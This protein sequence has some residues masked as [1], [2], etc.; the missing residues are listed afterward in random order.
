MVCPVCH[1]QN[2]EGDDSCA[3]CGADLTGNDVPEQATT[4]HGKLLGAHL[5]ELGAPAPEI[6]DGD[7]TAREAI[8]RMRRDSADCLLITEGGRLV[9][10]FTDR[11]ALLKVRAGHE[12]DRPVRELMTHD[13]VV[14]R[15]DDPI[16]VAI[17]KMAVGGFRHIPVMDGEMPIGVVAARDVFRHFQEVLG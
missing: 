16:A 7:L 1:A 3:N 2:F 14:L 17:H 11:D 6:V 12:G 5:D 13:P 15:H 4:F 8:E 10:I 9:G